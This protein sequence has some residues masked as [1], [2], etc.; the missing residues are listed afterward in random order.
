MR[1]TLL[2]LISSVLLLTATAVPAFAQQG[3]GTGATRV[4]DPAFCAA[5]MSGS[6][7]GSGAA[8]GTGGAG[9]GAGGTDDITV[10][11]G[12]GGGGGGSAP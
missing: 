3:D 6:G 12:G 5:T 7:D 10:D 1:K 9:S 8:N 11:C 2:A 4:T